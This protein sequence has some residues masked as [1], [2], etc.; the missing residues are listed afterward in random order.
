MYCCTF[1]TVIQV[2]IQYAKLVL[3]ILTEKLRLAYDIKSGNRHL[4]KLMHRS[5]IPHFQLNRNECFSCVSSHEENNLQEYQ[6]KEVLTC[7]VRIELYKKLKFVQY[8]A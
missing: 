3:L 6:L 5:F 4:K 8:F 1:V 7:I 2:V